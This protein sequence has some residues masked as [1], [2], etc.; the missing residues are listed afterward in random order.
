[1][2]G[3]QRKPTKVGANERKVTPIKINKFILRK[4][5]L[6]SANCCLYYMRKYKRYIVYFNYRNDN[7]VTTSL[8]EGRTQHGAN[9]GTT[10]GY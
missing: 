6:K 9:T 1:M 8:N 10:R 4:K 3:G 2:G 7:E 5:Q